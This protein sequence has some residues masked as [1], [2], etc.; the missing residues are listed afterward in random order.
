MLSCF[1]WCISG[2]VLLLAGAACW[3]YNK[4]FSLNAGDLVANSTENDSLIA[5]PVSKSHSEDGELKLQ[6]FQADL[7]Y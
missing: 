2:L 6:V 3:S 5:R 4:S 1:R 7:E